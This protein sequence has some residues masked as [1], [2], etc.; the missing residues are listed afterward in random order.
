MQDSPPT[1]SNDPATLATA[2][3]APGVAPGT[4]TLVGQLTVPA[5]KDVTYHLNAQVRALSAEVVHLAE[6]KSSSGQLT[7]GWVL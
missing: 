7:P 3:A 4:P 2:A 1:A 5:G 6:Q